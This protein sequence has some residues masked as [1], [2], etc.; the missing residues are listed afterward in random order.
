MCERLTFSREND[1][2]RKANGTAASQSKKEGDAESKVI[3]R[4]KERK[5]KKEK[6]GCIVVVVHC[7][8]ILILK[9]FAHRKGHFV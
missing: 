3:R 4:E 2:G 1:K 8:A 7:L 6:M 5:K 9:A